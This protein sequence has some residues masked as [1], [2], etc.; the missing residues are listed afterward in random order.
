MLSNLREA[1]SLANMV[2]KS[3]RLAQEQTAGDLRQSYMIRAAL[4]VEKLKT[5]I[6]EIAKE[7]KK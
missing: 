7:V 5:L 2:E 3:I 6:E 4:E 1:W